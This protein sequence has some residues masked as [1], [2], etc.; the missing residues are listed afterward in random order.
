M[1]VRERTDREVTLAD[2][3]DDL[4]TAIQAGTL[5]GLAYVQETDNGRRFVSFGT[6]DTRQ[7]MAA[8]LDKIVDEPEVRH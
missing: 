7:E 8:Y 3:L 2:V 6:S 5:E 1:T 4:G